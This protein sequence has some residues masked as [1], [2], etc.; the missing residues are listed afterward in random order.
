MRHILELFRQQ[1]DPS[2]L[3]LRPSWAKSRTYTCG[4]RYPNAAW[5]RT[6]AMLR[7]DTRYSTESA[8]FTVAGKLV[9][10]WVIVL[11]ECWQTVVAERP[12]S[13]IIVNL[14]D[15]TFI[16][17]AGREL[18]TRMCREGVALAAAGVLTEGIIEEIKADVDRGP[19]IQPGKNSNTLVLVCRQ[20]FGR[21]VERVLR[22]EGFG[23]FR[24]GG[25]SLAGGTGTEVRKGASEVFLLA[26]DSE[27]AR[28]LVDMLRACPIQGG[29][30]NLF[31]LYTVRS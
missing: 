17:D 13:A 29:A 11:E 20:P 6:I 8:N 18:L 9:G 14:G 19:I 5:I 31:E 10:P 16:D 7:I 12:G 28:R 22:R 1:I 25:L 15:V 4:R 3:K 2:N 23:N 30:E 21:I 27:S 24:H 26:A